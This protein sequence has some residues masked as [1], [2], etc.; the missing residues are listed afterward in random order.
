MTS[1]NG[2]LSWKLRSSASR[3]TVGCDA[4]TSQLDP[5]AGSDGSSERIECPAGS[6]EWKRVVLQNGKSAGV[7]CLTVNTGAV[8]ATILPDRGMGLWKC[9]ANQLELGWQSPVTGPVHP[10]L[11]PVQDATGI[12]WLEGF[13]ELLVRCGLYSNGAPEFNANGTVRHPLHGRIA[14]LP[15]HNLEIQ[16]DPQ[17]GILD[18]IGVVSETRFL[19]YSLE[20]ETRYRFR[21]GSPV[22]EVTDIVRN[23]STKPGSMQLLYHINIGDPIVDAGASIN[24]PIQTLVPRDA[25]AKEGVDQ[26]HLCEAPASGFQ[27]QVYLITPATDA[28]GW[29]EAMLSSADHSFGCSVQFD[30][31]TLPFLNVWKNTGAREDG[32]VVGLEPA[33]GFPN[34][35]SV[36]EE[37]GRVVPLAGGESRSFHLRLVPLTH[38]QDVSQAK[39]RIDAIANRSQ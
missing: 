11:V 30:T 4:T 16:V 39:A 22:I 1:T 32:N 3:G 21:A 8:E 28:Q 37:Q 24:A 20:L 35:R 31:K 15:A 33:T 27:E 36:E 6:L 23:C 13:D 10:S 12:G 2:I 5:T 26:W 19:V 18:V 25:R 9:W 14:N 38:S 34:P 17:N 7:E 29:S